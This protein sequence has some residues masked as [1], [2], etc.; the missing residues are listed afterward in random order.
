MLR[1][2]GCPGSWFASNF[3]ADVKALGMRKL[4]WLLAVLAAPAVGGLLYQKFGTWT[5][6]RRYARTGRMVRTATTSVYVNELGPTV[7]TTPTVIF[8]SGIG[9]TSQNW[10]GLQREV[11]RQMRT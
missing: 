7:T 8:E 5:D 3:V 6:R 4:L 11:A 2:F 1:N 10:L 9:A